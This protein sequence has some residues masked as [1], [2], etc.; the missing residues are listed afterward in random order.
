MI[1]VTGATGLVGSHLLCELSKKSSEIIACCRNAAK[2]K[3]VENLFHFYFSESASEHFAKIT[4]KELDINDLYELNQLIREGDE[5]YHCAALVSFNRKDFN[6]LIKINREGTANIVNTCLDNKARKLCYVSSTAAIGGGQQGEIDEKSQW[7]KSN[8]T[9]AYSVSKYSAEK[10]VWRGI[11][12]GLNAVMVNPCVI[13]GPGNWNEGSLTILKQANKG[14]PFY[15]S[16]ANATVDVRDV[17]RIMIRLME[18]EIQ[19]ERYLLIGSNQSF[20]ELLYQAA[21][22]M[23]KK[24]PSILVPDGLIKFIGAIGSFVSF[25]FGIPVAITRDSSYS[26][27]G[28]TNYSNTKIKSELSYEFHSLEST[29]ENAIA[30]KFD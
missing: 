12:E 20:R 14:L 9:S 28:R 15:T 19:A 26:A 23:K 30:G 29:L 1:I 16:G 7:K 5:V 13:L 8:A 24:T 22:Q 3:A 27:I 21:L 17:A 2:I 18:S 10:E 11:E 6:T 25:L 4:W